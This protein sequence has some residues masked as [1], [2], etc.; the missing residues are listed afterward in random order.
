M[1]L[2]VRLSCV[3]STDVEL[4]QGRSRDLIDF[5]TLRDIIRLIRDGEKGGRGDGGGGRGR[6]HTYRYT[7]TTTTM[8]P[9]LRCAAMRAILM[10]H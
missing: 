1:K 9:L 7:L 8:T 4:G 10:F 2:K 5:V 3:R 6:L